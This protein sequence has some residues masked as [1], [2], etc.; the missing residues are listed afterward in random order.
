MNYW[1]EKLLR[2]FKLL[3]PTA[4][5]GKRVVEIGGNNASGCMLRNLFNDRTTY[6]TINLYTPEHTEINYIGPAHESLARSVDV[7]ACID[8][9]EHDKHWE[10]TLSWML[11]CAKEWFVI[12]WAG[13]DFPRHGVKDSM[14]EESPMTTDTY[15]GKLTLPVVLDKL[16]KAQCAAWYIRQEAG[17]FFVLGRR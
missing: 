16:M 17:L 6:Y 14:P 3:H 4:F 10:K 7:V 12:S 1:V 9:L 5:E 13:P 11:L 8:V 15:N 2:D